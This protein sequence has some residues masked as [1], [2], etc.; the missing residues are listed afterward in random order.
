MRSAVEELVREASWRVKA[1]LRSRRFF[2]QPVLV[3]LH[4]RRILPFIESKTSGYYRVAAGI[5][6]SLDAVQKRFKEVGTNELTV[7]ASLSCRKDM[8]MPGLLHRV[9]TGVAPQQL[10][11]LLPDLKPESGEAMGRQNQRTMKLEA[12]HGAKLP[13]EHIS[14]QL[15]WFGIGL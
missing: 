7:L 13:H 9:A 3:T 6:A 4:K 14:T 12:V 11:S 1:L 5:L 10:R 15:V 2:T 8:A